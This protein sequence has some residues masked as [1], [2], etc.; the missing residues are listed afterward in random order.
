ME[1]ILRYRVLFI[2]IA[3]LKVQTLKFE[4]FRLALKSIF[5]FIIKYR[6]RQA[7]VSE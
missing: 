2:K 6:T 7:H 5:H 1:W 3:Q 4:I